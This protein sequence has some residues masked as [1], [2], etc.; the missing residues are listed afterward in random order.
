MAYLRQG[1]GLLF[2]LLAAGFQTIVVGLVWLAE[3]F[4]FED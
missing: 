3:W 1:A 2:T 4:S